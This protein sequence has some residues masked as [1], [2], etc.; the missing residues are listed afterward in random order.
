[1]PKHLDDK[2]VS[3]RRSFLKGAAIAAAPVAAAGAAAAVA[4]AGVDLAQPVLV[5]GADP[6]FRFEALEASLAFVDRHGRGGS[7]DGDRRGGDGGAL[8]EGAAAGQ[9][10]VVRVL[11]HGPVP[12][13]FTW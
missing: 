3:S 10:L 6:C 1:M 11:W 2:T 12:H 7:G 4:V 8:E 9:G 13:D 5:R